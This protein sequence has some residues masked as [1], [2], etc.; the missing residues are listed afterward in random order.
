MWDRYSNAAMGPTLSDRLISERRERA[1]R[2]SIEEEYPMPANGSDP[3]VV[4]VVIVDGPRGA[5]A[6][7]AFTYGEVKVACAWYSDEISFAE[8][9]FLG[10][11][12]AQIECM[13]IRRDVT[14][15]R[16]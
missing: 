11:T 6:L 14:Y 1:P 2:K 13:R 12:A 16:G 10:K 4:D 5:S 7:C 9:E 8:S 3:V 15:L